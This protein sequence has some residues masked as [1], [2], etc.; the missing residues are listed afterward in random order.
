MGSRLLLFW[1]LALVIG[2]ASAQEPKS[3]RIAFVAA[4]ADDYWKV[5]E[6]AARKA[7]TAAQ[8]ELIFQK[9]ADAVLREQI[10]LYDNL[11]ALKVDGIA[12]CPIDGNTARPALAKIAKTMPLVLYDNEWSDTGRTFAVL[13]DHKQGGK[14]AGQLVKEAH[15]KGATVAVFVGA[16]Q[17]FVSKERFKGLCAELGIDVE[18][19]DKSKDGKYRV[20]TREP[21]TDNINPMQAKQNALTALA[22][23]K[24][25]P[26]VC[27]V[28][29]W[30]Y[31][32]AALLEAAKEQG[33]VGKV[34]LIGFEEFGETLRG[35]DEGSIYATV[36]QNPQHMA[37]R[38]IEVLVA[39]AR[40]KPVAVPPGGVEWVPHRITT[41]AGGAGRVKASELAD[42]IQKILAP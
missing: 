1:A 38:C 6:H 7:A 11:V 27:L 16:S 2:L 34:T 3:L 12:T 30:G 32:P 8:A 40:K 9:P 18:K 26:N 25:Q 31:H 29:L 36:I 5:V 42:E 41:K 10:K 24:D 22:R 13:S 33:V 15:P 4:S 14:L 37:T 20:L 19:G 28:G 23:V 39:K 35:I 17:S 21:F